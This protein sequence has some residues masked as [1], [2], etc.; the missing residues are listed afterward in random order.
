[1]AILNAYARNFETVLNH[2]SRAPGNPQEV[3]AN[4]TSNNHSEFFYAVL[5]AARILTQQK[6]SDQAIATHDLVDRQTYAA[7]GSGR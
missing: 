6:E 4:T 1:M 2:P 7:V 3:S 5:G